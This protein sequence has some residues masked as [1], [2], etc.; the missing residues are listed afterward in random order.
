VSLGP[1]APG[2]I[3]ARRKGAQRPQA[4]PVCASN[5]VLQPASLQCVCLPSPRAGM[6]RTRTAQGVQLEPYP[7]HSGNTHWGRLP[8]RRRPGPGSR[9]RH[10][11]TESSRTRTGRHPW[12]MSRSIPPGTLSGAE[13]RPWAAHPRR[14]CGGREGSSGDKRLWETHI[15]RAAFPGRWK[16]L[17]TEE[18]WE[19]LSQGDHTILLWLGPGRS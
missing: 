11:S 15:P 2:R 12:H 8:G 4:S 5:S 3:L 9:R 1:G 18:Q 10:C 14:A 19:G 6:P 17:L 13:A 7:L 16:G